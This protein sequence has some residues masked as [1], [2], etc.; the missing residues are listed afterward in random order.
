MWRVRHWASFW[1]TDDL[2]SR[3]LGFQVFVS[4][5]LAYGL[6]PHSAASILGLVSAILSVVCLLEFV[7]LYRVSKG[8]VT[9]SSCS[10]PVVILVAFGVVGVAGI[11]IG[12]GSFV[13][14]LGLGIIETRREDRKFLAVSGDLP[15]TST[16]P[17]CVCVV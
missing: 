12:F 7:F 11:G 1:E 8:A 9:V 13:A 4:D 15:M 10:T 2:L 17:T 14:F 16:C 3:Q 6:F 5:E